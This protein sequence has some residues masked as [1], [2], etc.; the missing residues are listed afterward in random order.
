MSTS[1]IVKV[2][3]LGSVGRDIE[4]KV[5]TPRG[6]FTVHTSSNVELDNSATAWLPS[7]LPVAMNSKSKLVLDGTV[8]DTAYR[9]ACK[10]RTLLTHWFRELHE[11]EIETDG[12]QRSPS[13]VSGVGC[14]FSG[15]VDSYYT[16]LEEL[17]RITH[18]IFVHGFDIETQDDALAEK[19]IE[20]ARDAAYLLGKD[21]IVVRTNLRSMSDKMGCDWPRRYVGAALAH[22]GLLLSPHVSTVIIPSS[23]HVDDLMPHGT[24]PA[25][26]PLWSS[27]SVKLE[28][29]GIEATRTQRV[30]R[31]SKSDVA[32]SHLRV[33][34][35]NRDGA[36]NCGRCEK[37]VRTM[38]S[39]RAVGAKC[40]TMPAEI[41]MDSLHNMKLGGKI[42]RIF[43]R[44]NINELRRSDAPDLGL[45]REL[46]RA[47][48]RDIFIFGPRR[49][50][51]KSVKDTLR[52][53]VRRLL[54]AR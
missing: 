37:C 10:A 52:P 49:V 32:M 8:D 44:N 28:H 24:H 50:I 18:L 17:D 22:I 51:V 26:D 47:I 41:P 35:E 5:D 46:K 54:P 7:A 39:L 11:S 12:V 13:G 36:F 19:A 53:V 20:S 16:V 4:T 40:S 45:E 14:F 42:G 25:L 29:H 30:R 21:L 9:G 34:W 31:I 27:A 33:C 48:R 3:G 15:G 2:H 38:I 6:Q 43:A 23:H 1:K